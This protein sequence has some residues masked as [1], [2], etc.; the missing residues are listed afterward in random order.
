MNTSGTAGVAS[1][2]SQYLNSLTNNVIQ[3]GLK[4]AMPINVSGLN[5]YPDFLSFILVAIITGDG[6]RSVPSLRNYFFNMLTK[7]RLYFAVLLA[8]GVKESTMF[9]NVCT[10]F[11]LLVVVY[12]VIC[13]AFKAKASNWSISKSEASPYDLFYNQDFILYECD[14]ACAALCPYNLTHGRYLSRSIAIE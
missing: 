4:E 2:Y 11:N 13:G 3:D 8:V 1:G 7:V 6:L 5:T 10:S 9:N 14:C 12:V